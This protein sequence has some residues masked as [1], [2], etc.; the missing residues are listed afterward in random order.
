MSQPQPVKD[1]SHLYEVE[2]RAFHA[3][4]PAFALRNYSSLQR[5]KCRGT[6]TPTCLIRFTFWKAT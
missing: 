3:E 2:R 1:A 5:R 6:P 4:R